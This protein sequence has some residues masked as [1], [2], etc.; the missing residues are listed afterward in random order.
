M[1]PQVLIRVLPFER[2]QVLIQMLPQVL[3]QML[4]CGVDS[5]ADSDAAQVLI[6][7]LLYKGL[8]QMLPQVD[9]DV[10]S[11]AD[12]DAA[13]GADSDAAQVLI[14]MLPQVLIQML[15]QV[16][17][18]MLPQVLIQMLPQVLVR[19]PKQME[20]RLTFSEMVQA[21]LHAADDG[22]KAFRGLLG[23]SGQTNDQMKSCEALRTMGAKRTE[24]EQPTPI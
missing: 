10:A 18:Q 12:S 1:L 14:Q 21:C 13:S 6:Q 22:A 24:R 15:P 19:V 16:L 11:G 4:P 2:I 9:S 20:Q 3:I 17:I 5:G 7:M 8:I 23:S